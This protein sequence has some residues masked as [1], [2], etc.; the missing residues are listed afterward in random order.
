MATTAG[1]ADD[2]RWQQLARVIENLS[3]QVHQLADAGGRE[4]ERVTTLEQTAR[5]IQETVAGFAQRQGTGAGPGG[6]RLES[7][8]LVGKM[9]SP[10][11]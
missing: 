3:G 4:S 6:D 2:E 5:Q 9:L 10:K 1:A 11:D 8:S 7:N